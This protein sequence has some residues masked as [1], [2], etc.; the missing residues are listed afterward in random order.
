L[1][2]AWEGAGGARACRFND[3]PFIEVRW[4]TDFVGPDAEN[5]FFKNLEGLMGNL[6]ELLIDWASKGLNEDNHQSGTTGY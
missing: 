3:M 6:G 1:A 4:I 5:D 2:V